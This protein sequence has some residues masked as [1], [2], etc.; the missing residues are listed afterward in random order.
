MVLFFGGVVIF[1]HFYIEASSGW[2]G[3]LYD[4]VGEMFC[5]MI[6]FSADEL[7]MVPYR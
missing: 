4:V 3:R 2:L 5:G 7:L 6:I 1:F